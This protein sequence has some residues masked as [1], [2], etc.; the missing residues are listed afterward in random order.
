MHKFTYDKLS[1][2]VLS[3]EEC[4]TEVFECEDEKA[5]EDIMSGKCRGFVKNGKVE[6]D[7]TPI[8]VEMNVVP[9]GSIVGIPKAEY[10]RKV[11]SGEIVE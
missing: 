8:K 6:L 2:E 9:K 5:C 7:Y 11:M 3:A 1:G 4:T 10:D